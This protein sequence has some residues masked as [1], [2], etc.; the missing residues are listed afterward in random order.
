M[1]NVDSKEKKIP[2]VPNLRFKDF[3][4]NWEKESIDKLMLRFDNLRIPVS[5]SQRIKGITPYYGA[6]GI[7]DY[8][9]GFTHDGE[10][11]LIAE[12]GANDIKN[13]PVQYVNGK[14]WVNNH[15]HVL[16]AKEG[17]STLFMKYRFNSLDLTPYLS[18][19]GRYKLNA[20]VLMKINSFVPSFKEQ[21]KIAC[22]LSLLD[23]RI[24]TQNKIIEDLKT[25]IKAI[26][27]DFFTNKSNSKVGNYITEISLRNKNN[28]CYP[29]FSVSNKKG[30]IPQIEQFE[31]KVI[32]SDDK[33]SYK[34]VSK[35]TFAYNPARI[36]VGSIGLYELDS[37]CIVS[38]MYNCFS[39][40]EIDPTYLLMFF[41][42][43]FFS[44]EMNKRLE[45]SVRMCLTMDGL[46]NIPIYIPP[47]D[48]MDK[49]INIY[50]SI[51]RKLQNSMNILDL[52][53][54]QKE[55]LLSNLFI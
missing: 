25:S 19:C 5:E 30:F 49:V 17:N 38:P 15:A 4:G 21:I 51:N 35:N 3:D 9:E 2:N 53:L 44:N 7:Q 36:N 46:K 20:E 47:A 14:I 55:Y 34:I 11:I 31:D 8:V 39:V 23:E 54:K 37:P 16:K 10:F 6:N 26:L 50:L 29:V 52:Y 28:A 12:D 27:D 48:E 18:G 45:G 1:S 32:A 42:S 22:F 24:I 41:K 13:Y 40:T 43:S 33:G